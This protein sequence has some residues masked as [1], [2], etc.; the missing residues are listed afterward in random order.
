MGIFEVI[1]DLLGLKLEANDLSLLQV[2][3]RAVVVLI[4]T[5]VMVRVAEKR[6]LSRVNALDAILAFILGSML[7]RAINGSAP[8]FGTLAGGFVLVLF[9]RVLSAWA[10]RSER[11]GNLVKGTEE[12]L[13]EN[14]KVCDQP[15]RRNHITEKDLFE[16]L[17][18]NGNL[19]GLHKVKK[20][21]M[22]RNGEISVVKES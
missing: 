5:L 13:I 14:G 17:R 4:A 8:F 2:S 19:D 9:H 3:L 7:S 21:V 12:I 11:F 10:Y 15:L 18:L 22:E 1:S 20:A 6:F 16:E